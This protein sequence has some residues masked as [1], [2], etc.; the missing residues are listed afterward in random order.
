VSGARLLKASIV[1]ATLM[2]A[3]GAGAKEEWQLEAGP[4]LT[5]SDVRAHN[6][7]PLDIRDVNAALGVQSPDWRAALDRFAF[8]G[9]FPNHS[10]AIFTDDYNDRFKTHLPVS[11]K[12]F[13]DEAFQN[14]AITAAIVGSGKFRKSEPAE[15][16]AFIA[17][18][19]E[20]VTIN[21]SRYELGESAR[22]ATAAEPNWSLENG[23]PKNWNEIFAFYWGPEGQHS[24]YA[25]VDKVAD[26]QT[27]NAGLLKS[28]ADGQT[29][30]VGKAWTPEHADAV[31]RHLDEASVLLLKDALSKAATA[32]GPE[33][34][35]SKAK[36][37]GYWLAAAE[38]V[39]ENADA[40]AAVEAALA[41][42]APPATVEAA[43]KALDGAA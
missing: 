16:A 3:T 12:Y 17:A 21:W 4:F 26:G 23:S 15:R 30:V 10:L 31:E 5:A 18:A 39:A 24:A 41:P 34:A 22:K 6:K 8:G 37:A 7:M 36:A 33:A 27:L 25:A 20:S 38:A 29:V 13:G 1:A 43:L 2:M 35:I 28:L 19:L 9:N 42:D 11:S 32:A 14:Q 40:A